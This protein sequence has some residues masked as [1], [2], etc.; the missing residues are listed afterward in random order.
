MLKK[1]KT[2]TSGK[3]VLVTVCQKTTQTPL[4]LV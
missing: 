2:R 3:L 4:F 1:K